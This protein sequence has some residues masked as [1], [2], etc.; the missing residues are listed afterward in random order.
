MNATPASGPLQVAQAF[1]RDIRSPE[2]GLAGQGFRFALSGSV[3]AVVYVTIT[4]LLHDGFAVPFQLALAVGFV[5]SVALHFTLQ[6]LFVWRHY[7]RFALEVHRQ[8]GRYL[9]M[10]AGQYA[11]TALATAKLP[12]LLGLPVDAVYVLTM[13][14][15]AGMNFIV[16]RGRVFHADVP[17]ALGAISPGEGPPA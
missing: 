5:L 9:M 6:R 2:W 14:T 13:L 17:R 3:V 1:V 11:V 10:C 15:V 16:L 12:G 8:A 4:A 7:E